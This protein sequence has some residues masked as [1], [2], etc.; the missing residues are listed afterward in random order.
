[1]K[2]LGCYIFYAIFYIILLYSGSQ[3]Y[4]YLRVLADRTFH[5]ETLVA[6]L[7]IF[8]IIIGMFLALP[9]FISKAREQ[10]SWTID[11]A[12]LITRGYVNY[13]RMKGTTL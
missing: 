2:K 5:P 7:D 9:D 4:Q 1:M 6:F 13:H 12:K 11:W 8:P 3:I 10:G